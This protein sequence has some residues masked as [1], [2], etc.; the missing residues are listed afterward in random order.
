MSLS[1]PPAVDFGPATL[2]DLMRVEGKAELVAGRIIHQV[3]SGFEPSQV[4]FEIA[5]SLRQYARERGAGFAFGDGIGYACQPPLSSG[6]QSFSPDASFYPGP[7]SE[8]PMK[9][10]EGHPLFAV[11]VWSENDGPAAEAEMEAKRADYF[12]AGTRI[13]W[14]VDPEAR[15][16]AAFADGDPTT[17]ARTFRPGETADAEPVLPGWHLAVADIFP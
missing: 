16:I 14:D 1:T 7:R 8:R 13:V 4:A 11:E 9:F 15:T 2:D 3:A 12:E 5:V 17:P 10:I 6:R